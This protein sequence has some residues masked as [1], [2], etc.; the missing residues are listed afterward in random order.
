[1]SDKDALQRRLD[2]RAAHCAALESR[3]ADKDLELKAANHEL[4]IMHLEHEQRQQAAVRKAVDSIS[5]TLI[6]ERQRHVEQ[7]RLLREYEHVLH[8]RD[9][10]TTNLMLEHEKLKVAYEELQNNHDCCSFELANLKAN[11]VPFTTSSRDRLQDVSNS[12]TRGRRALSES[13]AASSEASALLQEYKR[14]KAIEQH[15]H[16]QQLTLKRVPK[17][18]EELEH[19][20]SELAKHRR[21]VGSM[22]VEVTRNSQS[23]G[24]HQMTAAANVVYRNQITSLQKTVSRLQDKIGFLQSYPHATVQQ[25]GGRKK[26]VLA[27]PQ[28]E[29]VAELSLPEVIV[30]ETRTDAGGR[31]IGGLQYRTAFHLLCA[32]LA[33]TASLAYEKTGACVDLVLQRLRIGRLDKLPSSATLARIGH[34]C[35]HLNIGVCTRRIA[36]ESVDGA[37]ALATDGTQHTKQ[38]FVSMV[39]YYMHKSGGT[40]VFS[41][42]I[43]PCLRETGEELCRMTVEQFQ[44][45]EQVAADVLRI[46]YTLRT[47]KEPA[48]AAVAELASKAG[49][50]NL[51]ATMADHAANETAFNRW[52]SGVIGYD[53]ARLGCGMHMVENAAKAA[54]DV[55]AILK[56][57]QPELAELT[58][59]EGV[60]LSEVLP[61]RL[62]TEADIR[63]GKEGDAG[64]RKTSELLVST[65][66]SRIGR[67]DADRRAIVKEAFNHHQ[68]R[69]A[70]LSEGTYKAASVTSIP[71][72]CRQVDLFVAV[73]EVAMIFHHPRGLTDFLSEHKKTDGAWTNVLT[74][75][76]ACCMNPTLLLEMLSAFAIDVTVLQPMLHVASCGTWLDMVMASRTA[77]TELRKIVSSD[78]TLICLLL[79][80]IVRPQRNVLGAFGVLPKMQ[81]VHSGAGAQSQDPE[82][83]ASGV[84]TICITPASM[85]WPSFAHMPLASELALC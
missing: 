49:L 60:A 54:L 44:M 35:H 85:P 76:E 7:A 65:L 25:H 52:L 80:A 43:L 23:Q 3:L 67:Y 81:H 78:T 72:A 53:L 27:V 47:G 19:A 32:E 63:L 10:E 38:T 68:V 69:Q 28:H 82:C 24:R 21:L 17:L 8:S 6:A 39:V 64:L 62:P 18:E 30:T 83:S 4:R 13:R 61:P 77:V 5:A 22:R 71:G 66:G 48:D 31:C 16:D 2:D 9:T 73:Q 59:A 79:E 50:R 37:K 42:G 70:A 45:F 14:L 15:L 75:L 41:V 34:A 33:A 74:N 20:K 36:L 40:R 11:P 57:I 1:M 55:T 29:P 26:V 56:S 84:I 46:E 12:A 58:A 51:F